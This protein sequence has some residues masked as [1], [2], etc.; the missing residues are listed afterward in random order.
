MDGSFQLIHRGLLKPQAGPIPSSPPLIGGKRS[1]MSKK[2]RAF[3]KEDKAVVMGMVQRGGQVRGK[4]VPNTTAN[5]LIPHVMENVAQGTTVNTDEWKPYSHLPGLGYTHVSLNHQR[6]EYAKGIHHTNT[7]EG[8]WSHL[9]RG[10]RSTHVSVSKG[11]LQK[12]VDEFAFRFN[13]RDEPAA[14]FQRLVRQVSR[15][16]DDLQLNHEGTVSG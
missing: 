2:R 7:I 13:N 12:Y 11:H 14:M 15:K 16:A 4:V 9:K 6:E 5:T 10:I 8:F 1:Y 3:K